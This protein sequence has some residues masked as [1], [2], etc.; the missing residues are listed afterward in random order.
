MTPVELVLSKL[1]D[2]KRN[3]SGWMARC[4]A[5][6]DGRASLSVAVGDD[7]RALVHCHA[8]C[9][10]EAIVSAMGLRLADLMPGRDRR[11]CPSPRAATTAKKS[12]RRKSDSTVYATAQDAIAE[13]E[14]KHG[15]RSAVW[16]YEDAA[17]EPVGMIVRWDT[18]GDKDIRPVSKTARGWIIGGMLEPRPLYRLPELLSRPDERV[19][20][21]EGEKAA[22]AAASIGLLATTSPHGCE[23]AGK[24]DWRPLAGRDVVILPDN[25]DAGQKYA[26]DVASIL[27]K[28]DQTTRVTIVELPDLPPKGDIYDWLEAHD[29]SEPE[30]LRARIEALVEAT[31]AISPSE[32][33]GGPILTCLA[34]VER[35]DIRWLWP[36]RVPLGRITLLVGRPGE[37]KS[38]L[39][40]YM[41]SRISTGSPWPDG[42]DCP[43]G[44]VILVSAEDDPGD[45]IRPRLDAHYA[46][47]RRVHLLAMVR[48]IQ[49]DGERHDVMFTLADID[50]LEAALRTH[51]DCKL[52]VVDPIGSFLGG[53]TD[54]HRDNEVRSVLAPVTRLAEKY[55]P[56]VLIVAHR[57]K[58]SGSIADDLALGS[59]AFTGIARSVWHLT[60]DSENK[61]RRLLLPGKN[62]LAVEGHGLAFTICGQPP[63]IVWE[64]DPVAMTA[65]DA[66]ATENSSEPKR[67]GPKPEARN[68]A[69]EWLRD[70]LKTGPMESGKVKVEATEAGYAW[71]TV[72]RAKDELGIVPRRNQFGGTWIWRLPAAGT[73]QDTSCHDPPEPENLASW[74]HSDGA[75]ENG[76]S[77]TPDVL[78]CQVDES[79]TTDTK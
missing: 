70:L 39:T 34:D 21:T 22:D 25:D 58:S 6:D 1:Q 41:A 50:A 35:V 2:A 60:R 67:P 49:A 42:T 63:A 46:D 74:H 52:V 31:P 65:D 26:R 64:H 68:K 62:N 54:A 36:G 47:V 14:R 56:A 27:V 24:A 69:A 4:P 44:S 61:R 51:P 78:S 40:T 33:I 13:L 55:G 53:R 71:R 75:D 18:A 15:P 16:T 76:V 66:L 12:G 7:G 32:V 30:A 23:S 19:Y 10:P 59:R 20:V 29:A 17:G 72:Q 28:Q 57:R 5:H 43:R 3:G 79:G 48:R 11:P 38:F 9:T 73:C 8:G 45:T 37:G 77:G